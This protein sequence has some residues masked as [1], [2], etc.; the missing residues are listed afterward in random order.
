[1]KKDIYQPKKLE[2]LRAEINTKL[3]KKKLSF[4][5]KIINFFLGK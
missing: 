4:F 2:A 1:M 3:E 5:R